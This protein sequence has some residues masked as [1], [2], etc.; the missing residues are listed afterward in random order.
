MILFELVIN[1]IEVLISQNMKLTFDN[2][3]KQLVTI[4]RC[5]I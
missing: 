5:S 1:I 3:I 4:F 2:S